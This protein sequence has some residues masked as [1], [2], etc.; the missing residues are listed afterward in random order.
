MQEVI[1]TRSNVLFVHGHFLFNNLN[2]SLAISRSCF[3]VSCCFLIKACNKNHGGAVQYK[4]DTGN[5][6]F[7]PNT[8]L[9]EARAHTPNQRHAQRPPKLN[10]FDVFT[11]RLSFYRGQV[12]ESLPDGLS[13]RLRR[14]KT[15]I[16]NWFHAGSVSILVRPARCKIGCGL[17]P[18]G[19]YFH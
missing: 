19:F 4:Q 6:V 8:Y 14:K 18:D 3:G 15:Y 10:G 13:A 1:K 7:Q 5:A 9:P 16:K 17:R 12:F 2:R 11:H